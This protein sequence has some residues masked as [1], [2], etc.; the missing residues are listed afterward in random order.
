MAQRK[1]LATIIVHSGEKAHSEAMVNLFEVAIFKGLR[2]G[3]GVHTAR[4][5]TL[6]QVFELL[7]IPKKR[8]EVLR[9]VEPV[10]HSGGRGM[11]EFNAPED[12]LSNHCVEALKEIETICGSGNRPRG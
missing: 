7:S 6:P 3:I 5:R 4:Y 10:L 9:Y 2:M 11:L 1:I 12:S 8:G